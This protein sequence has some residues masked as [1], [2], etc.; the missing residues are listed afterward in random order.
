MEKERMIEGEGQR[1]EYSRVGAY[2]PFEYRIVADEEKDHIQAR[3][4]G[5]AAAPE[6]RPLPDMG[7]HD[8]I[9]GEW[10]KILNLKLDT[11][12]RLITLQSEG[13]FGLPFKAVS[14]SGGGMSFLLPQAIAPGTILEIKLMLTRNQPVAMRIYGEVTKSVQRDDIYFIAVR[15]VHMDVSIRDEIIRFVFEREREIIRKKRS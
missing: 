2:I 7:D 14:I 4:S 5:D 1:R 9:F 15:Y 8:Y 11:V 13:F 6:L 3:I 10:L 12:I